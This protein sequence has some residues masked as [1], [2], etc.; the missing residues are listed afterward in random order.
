MAALKLARPTNEDDRLALKAAARR[1]T[2]AS[3]GQEAASAITRVQHQ[4]ISR[5]GNPEHDQD[6]M[7]VDVVVDLTRDSGEPF[8]IR[9]MARQCGFG[10]HRI[11]A[12]T[13]IE[14]IFRGVHDIAK[15]TA[16]V[17]CA[18]IDVLK[19]GH[20]DDIDNALKEIED[21]LEAM[22]GMKQALLAMKEG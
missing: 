18:L 17:H 1:Q 5:Y 13:S 2:K 15:E 20:L 10:V 4:T 21:A 19:D 6:H 7:P 16:E 14:T 11:E 22:C 3:G 12:K 8:L 9:E